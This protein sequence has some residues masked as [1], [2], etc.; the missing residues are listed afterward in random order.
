MTDKEKLDNLVAEIEKRISRNKRG[1][2]LED[3]PEKMHQLI[4]E[5]QLLG[6]LKHFIDSMQEEPEYLEEET[7]YCAFSTSRY[8]DEDRKVLCDGCEEKCGYAQKEADWLQELHCKI[9]SLSKEDF[10]KVWAKYHQKEEPISEDLEKEIEMIRKYH[11]IND[12]FD[13]AELDG[14]TISNIARHFAAWQ[15]QQMMRS[16]T[17][18]QIE[19]GEDYLRIKCLCMSCPPQ[20]DGKL[21]KLII[22]REE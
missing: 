20:Y 13:K 19:I 9:D 11:F 5:G 18:G 15:K 6:E 7:N 1:K 17:D 3:I 14:R 2:V 8:T 4:I 16:A 21:V 10:E 12:D 22:I